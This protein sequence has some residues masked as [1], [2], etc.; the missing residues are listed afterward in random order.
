VHS[1]EAVRSFRYRQRWVRGVLRLVR[2]ILRV[3]AEHV[4]DG[5][6]CTAERQCS[7]DWYEHMCGRFWII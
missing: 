3:L 5:L 1:R 2:L 7:S 6:Q 4:Q